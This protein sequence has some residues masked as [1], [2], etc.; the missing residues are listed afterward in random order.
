MINDYN[1]TEIGG[2]GFLPQEKLTSIKLNLQKGRLDKAVSII[3]KVIEDMDNALLNIAVTGASGAGKSAFIN[4]F[5]GVGHEDEGAASTGVIETT[6]NITSYEHPEFPNVKLWDLPGIGTRDFQPESYLEQVKFSCYDFF[7]IISSSRFRVNDVKLAQK[8]RQMGKKFFFVRSKVD[9]DL[10]N[11]KKSKPKTFKEENVMQMIQKNCLQHLQDIGIEEPQVFLISSFELESY[12]FP[13]LKDDLA[14]ELPEHKRRVFFLSLPNISKDIIDQKKANI[15]LRI[16]L[17]ALKT[18]P[19]ATMP[20]IGISKEDDIAQLKKLLA[21]YQRKFGVDDA[22]LLKISQ[23]SNKPLEEVKA[24]IK[25]PHLLTIKKDEII[26]EKLLSYAEIFC[27]VNGSLLDTGLY[28]RKS[29]YTHLYFLEMVTNDAKIL[30]NKLWET[31]EERWTNM[32]LLNLAS[33]FMP[34][35]R[36][37]TNIYGDLLPED[38]I[39]WI[40]SAFQEGRLGEVA[41]SIQETLKASE[42]VL[43][44]IAVTGESGC[45]KSTFINAFRGIGHEE[46]D[47]AS[48]GVVETTM[49]ATAYEHPKYPNVKLWDLPG[50]GTPY[51]HPETYLNQVQFENYDFFIIL[52]ASRFTVNDV[53]LVQEIRERKKK[54]YFVRTMVD[55]DLDNERKFKP[56]SFSEERILQRVRNYCLQNLEGMSETQ[57]FLISNFDLSDYDFPKLEETLQQDLPAHKRYTF[58]LALPNVSEAVIERKKD[59]LKERIWLKALKAATVVIVPLAGFIINDLDTLDKSLKYYRDVFGVDDTSLLQVAQKLERPVEEIKASMKS[60]DLI[61]L[62]TEENIKGKLLKLFDNL[63]SPVAFVN[64]GFHFGKTYCLHVHFINT[65]ADDAKNLLNREE[66]ISLTPHPV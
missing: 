31:S 10:L 29:Y 25:S 23:A 62:L 30:L 28:F 18:G 52:S 16:W 59:A 64:A 14:K 15:Q 35:S 60:L 8:I 7:L 4:A 66:F 42:N 63:F 9:I 40:Q 55:I 50:I 48:T 58:L 11:E 39:T 46:K 36:M 53:K 2:L 44:N 32:D 6:T 21:N 37:A 43:L 20:F 24:L 26:S 47:S 5:R 34:Y 51:F 45:G 41:S 57:V 22:S 13:K 3:N 27:S 61:A 12:D 1:N 38:R 54:F 49:E 65:A 19:W 56:K 17:E 33:T